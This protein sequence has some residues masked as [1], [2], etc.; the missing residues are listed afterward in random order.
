MTQTLSQFIAAERR[1]VDP[2]LGNMFAFSWGKVLRRLCFLDVL[3][4]RYLELSPK[5]SGNFTTT[6]EMMSA[7]GPGI[8][9]K[10]KS[11]FK[12]KTLSNSENASMLISIKPWTSS[13]STEQIHD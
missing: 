2:K 5:L 13:L 8:L 1:E 6:Q 12:P 11:K 9:V 10:M 4:S 7:A 3:E